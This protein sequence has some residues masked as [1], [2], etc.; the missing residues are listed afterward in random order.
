M[1]LS[2]LLAL[3][4]GANTCIVSAVESIPYDSTLVLGNIIDPTRID[5]LKATAEA[6]K[7]LNLAEDK[8]QAN[9]RNKLSLDMDASETVR[10]GVYLKDDGKGGTEVDEDAL[11]VLKEA[12]DEANKAVKKALTD[13]V[14]AR[15]KYQTALTDQLAA[16]GQQTTFGSEPDS[17][18][19]WTNSKMEYL[20]LSSDTMNMNV[21]FFQNDDNEQ[22]S[23]LHT[24]K[25]ANFVQTTVST[26]FG[27]SAGASASRAAQQSMSDQ[28]EHHQIEATLVI[29]VTATH[30]KA[31]Q[32]TDLRW[33]ADKLVLAWNSKMPKDQKITLYGPGIK[34]MYN[35]LMAQ[36]KDEQAG[37][38]TA[39]TDLHILSGRTFG[40]SFIGFVHFV[41]TSDTSSFQNMQ[42]TAMAAQTEATYGA[43]F[44]SIT[45]KFGMDTSYNNDVKA[46]LSTTSLQS[47][48]SVITMG[49]IPSIASQQMDTAVKKFTEFSPD[50]L[51]GKLNVLANSNQGAARAGMDMESGAAESIRA[52]QINGAQKGKIESVLTGVSS[53]DAI[54]NQV[55][56]TNSLMLALDDYVKI[57]RD[58]EGGVPVNFYVSNIPKKTVISEW[59]KVYRPELLQCSI[60]GEASPLC[61]PPQDGDQPS[62]GPS[63]PSPE[64][65]APPDLQPQLFQAFAKAPI[66]PNLERFEAAAGAGVECT[67]PDGRDFFVGGVRKTTCGQDAWCCTG[68]A[69]ATQSNCRNAL[70]AQATAEA[71]EVPVVSIRACCHSGG[72]DASAPVH[73]TVA[74]YS[75]QASAYHPACPR[76]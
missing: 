72:T 54:T 55:L 40:S 22:G 28:K 63:P 24:L 18:I 8:Y 66:E 2:S 59:F 34:T 16:D 37:D 10:L 43:F 4:L 47:H 67:T 29:A 65:P 32:F 73:V 35:E 19:K 48:V 56:D 36:D 75:T 20:D 26:I 11:K 46:L 23:K 60:H 14:T 31:Q 53:T 69:L 68:G 39:E 13:K 52:G 45:G 15:T 50:E 6:Q 12:Q 51:E 30:K 74:T 42:A 61:R 44:A 9:L 25:V 64:P 70:S 62:P 27:G 1:K 58:M 71:L 7:D 41:K 33:D 21:Q 3:V 76:S 38:S 17:P 5:K 49:I 57:A